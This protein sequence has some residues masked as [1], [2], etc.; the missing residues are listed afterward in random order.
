MRVLYV[1]QTA[2]VSGAEHS[3]LALLAGLRGEVE[4]TLACPTGRLSELAAAAGIP[5]EPIVGTQASFRLH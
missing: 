3:L 1:N 2:D 4:P 5:T